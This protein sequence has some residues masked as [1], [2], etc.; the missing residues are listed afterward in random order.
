MAQAR[1][2]KNRRQP[3]AAERTVSPRRQ[4]LTRD[5]MIVAIVPVLVF[6]LVSL[7]TYSPQ[8]VGWSRS[9]AVE[10]VTHNACGVIGAY[11]ADFLLLLS[12]YVAFVLPF[13]LRSGKSTRLNSSH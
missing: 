13:L 8:D 10:G 3:T 2:N 5:M 12:G 9:G 4:R 6:L 11:V 1:I 7:L